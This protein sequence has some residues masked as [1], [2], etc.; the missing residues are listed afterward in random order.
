M[1]CLLVRFVEAENVLTRSW[2]QSHFTIAYR[3]VDGGL[4]FLL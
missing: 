2:L 4:N 1:T 3:N